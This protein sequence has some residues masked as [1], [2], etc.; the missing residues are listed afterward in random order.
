MDI[1]MDEA[2]KSQTAELHTIL[3]RDHFR[4]IMRWLESRGNTFQGS[5]AD[6][7]EI[8]VNFAGDPLRTIKFRRVMIMGATSVTSYAQSVDREDLKV[9]YDPNWEVIDKLVGLMNQ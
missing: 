2:L 6:I 3:A 5:P 8:P 1:T 9:Y 7:L 4:A